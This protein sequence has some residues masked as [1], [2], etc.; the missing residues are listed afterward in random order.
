MTPPGEE[1]MRPPPEYHR[2]STLDEALHLLSRKDRHSVV[3]SGRSRPV[4]NRREGGEVIVDVSALPLS[5][6]EGGS[7]RLRLGGMTTLQEIVDSPSVRCFA[8]GTLPD[9][10]RSTAGSVLRNQLTLAETLLSGELSPDLAVLLLV[11]GAEVLI[12][13]LGG[14]ISL[15]L[16]DLYDD[17][18]AV[19][20]GSI[21]AEVSVP[22]PE[23]M[24]RVCRCRLA[25]TT[26]DRALLTVAAASTCSEG[27]F[28]SVQV[29]AAGIGLPPR[30]MSEAESSLEGRSA[31][32]G[33]VSEAL[34]ALAQFDIPENDVAGS[35]YRNQTLK[36]L[37]RRAVLG[38]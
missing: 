17:V 18:R 8:S 36:V 27:T 25:R 28:R 14:S 31:D 26:A 37:I 13:R 30:R 9:A 29:A 6:V 22:A 7:S 2:P 10:A 38:D 16:A 4:P 5:Y 23:P 15:P 20:E 33:S 12:H 24:A 21:L 35:G 19:M 34:D 1:S 32:A 11:L 3:I